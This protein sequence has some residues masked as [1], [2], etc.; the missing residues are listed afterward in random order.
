LLRRVAAAGLLEPTPDHQ[1]LLF[2]R[3]RDQ[4][5]DR[6]RRLLKQPID[7]SRSERKE[8]LLSLAVVLLPAIVVASC[9]VIKEGKAGVVA[10]AHKEPP[11]E[12]Q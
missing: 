1:L 5:L 7:D 11:P 2:F 12:P 9:S 3:A 6:R 10:L 8:D 4:V